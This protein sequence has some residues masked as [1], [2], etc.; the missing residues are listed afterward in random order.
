MLFISYAQRSKGLFV[1]E[2]HILQSLF[3]FRGSILPL[4]SQN[5]GKGFPAIMKAPRRRKKHVPNLTEEI[6]EGFFY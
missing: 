1:N 2:N 6:S 4:E 3:L 5:G